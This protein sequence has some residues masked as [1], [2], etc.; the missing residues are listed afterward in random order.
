LIGKL[1]EI[2]YDLILLLNSSLISHSEMATRK[3]EFIA[4]E[5]IE[6]MNIVL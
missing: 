1:I 5:I 6:N 2:R 3:P 4:A